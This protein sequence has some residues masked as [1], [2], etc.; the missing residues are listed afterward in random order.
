[1]TTGRP[2]GWQ[3]AEPEPVKK[4]AVSWYALTLGYMHPAS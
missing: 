4:P 2:V 1:V 3:R